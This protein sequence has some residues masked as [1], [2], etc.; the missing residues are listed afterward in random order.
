MRKSKEVAAGLELVRVGRG[1][2][3]STEP[4]PAKSGQHPRHN[5]APPPRPSHPP[6][7][8]D[9]ATGEH[10]KT[11]L[12]LPSV[13]S[14]IRPAPPAIPQTSPL[15]AAYREAVSYMPSAPVGPVKLPSSGILERHSATVRREKKRKRSA[16]VDDDNHQYGGDDELYGDGVNANDDGAGDEDADGDDNGTLMMVKRDSYKD[17]YIT[18]VVM[19]GMIIMIVD[20]RD[21]GDDECRP[22]ICNDYDDESD[23]DDDCVQ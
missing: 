4:R 7:I 12:Q 18:M 17:R 9:A 14:R 3:V 8:R 22:I 2:P 5:Q 1:I 15:R 6:L 16:T 20:T 21:G 10:A 23:D 19:M 13:P 11:K